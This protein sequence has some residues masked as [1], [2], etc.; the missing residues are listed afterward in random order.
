[1]D[2]DEYLL[3]E[4][5][6][7]LLKNGFSPVINLDEKFPHKVDLF[8]Q[9]F[10]FVLERVGNYIHPHKWSNYRI[11]LVKK[12]SADYTCGIYKFKTKK[13][14]LVIIPAR[15]INSSKNWTPDSE[16]YFLLFNMDFFLQSHFPYKFLDNKRILQ[17]NIRPYLHL[18]EEQAGKV[19][20]I[21]KSIFKEKHGNNAH[22]KELIALKIIE[23]LILSERL[24]SEEINLYGN[25]VKLDLVKKFANLLEANFTTERTVTFYASALHIHPNYLN[26]LI[27]SHTGVTAK[28]SIQNRLL[29]ETKFLLH[30]TS[31]SVKE[32]SN[33]LGFDDPNYFT[34]FFKRVEGQSPLA[35]RSSLV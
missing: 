19:E 13:N 25:Q 17:S 2:R 26:A 6:K 14:T 16:G 1:L 12:G 3:S 9:V 33:Q 18:T 10:Q 7:V 28:E 34:V 29:L 23:L 27:K 5:K 4:F 22:K 21:F 24:Y 15:V 32:I 11:G 30:S 31:L 35:Y 20:E 8:V